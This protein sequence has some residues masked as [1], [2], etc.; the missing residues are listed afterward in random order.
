MR[1]IYFLPIFSINVFAHADNS[2]HHHIVEPL[3]LLLVG[4]VG[5]FFIRKIYRRFIWELKM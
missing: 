1:L 3:S 5:V 4:F 2:F